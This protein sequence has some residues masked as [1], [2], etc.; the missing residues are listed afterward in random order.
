M[1]WNRRHAARR[2]LATAVTVCGAALLMALGAAAALAS[3]FQAEKYPVKV[4]SE[5]TE[6]NNVFTVGSTKVECTT[7]KFESGSLSAASEDIVVHPS[8]EKCTA[9]GF[10]GATVNTTGCNYEL[11]TNGD[12]SVLCESGKAIEIEA[13]ECTVTVK[14]Q[15]GLKEVRYTNL[16]GPPKEVEV[17]DEVVKIA[18]STNGALLCPAEGEKATYKGSNVA[19]GVNPSNEAEK[20]GIE[21]S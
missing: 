2:A 13:G 16:A 8:Y 12:V 17:I 1:S 4:K 9:F 14:G 18:Y 21:V 11:S 3:Q 7:A 10:V 5:S 20:I 19:F 15:T 6:S